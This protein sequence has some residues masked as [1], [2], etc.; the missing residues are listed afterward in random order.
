MNELSQNREENHQI[1]N[2][3]QPVKMKFPRLAGE[4]LIVWLD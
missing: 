4:D 3:C 2:L 1:Y